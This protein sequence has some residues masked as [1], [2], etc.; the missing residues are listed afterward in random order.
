MHCEHSET[1]LTLLVTDELADGEEKQELLSHLEQCEA[2]RERLG[3]LRVTTRLL[4]EAAE[5]EPAP[6]LSAERRA[7]L[8]GAVGIAGHGVEQP[9][10]EETPG[11][12]D[13]PRRGPRFWRRL[14]PM[15][16]P[17]RSFV[18]TAAAAM[19]LVCL[20]GIITPTMYRDVD[21]LAGD[22]AL[23]ANTES[24]EDSPL[25]LKRIEKALEERL[26]STGE[27]VIHAP[28]LWLPERGEDVAFRDVPRTEAE[29]GIRRP[30]AGG[31]GDGDGDAGADGDGDGDGPGTGVDDGV[32]LAYFDA[33][34]EG[35]GNSVGSSES[36]K[37]EGRSDVQD[38]PKVIGHERM[39]S[40]PAAPEKEVTITADSGKGSLAPPDIST[41]NGQLSTPAR[42][43]W[44][45]S[46][47]RGRDEAEF[48]LELPDMNDVRTGGG[49]TIDGTG[50]DVVG[51]RSLNGNRAP[52]PGES[53]GN[54]RAREP[55]D[56]LVLGNDLNSISPK[57]S[58]VLGVTGS[59]D[60][61]GGIIQDGE[62]QT[63]TVTNGDSSTTLNSGSASRGRSS[64]GVVVDSG[65]TAKGAE[66]V[67]LTLGS[68]GSTQG[69]RV[70][71][72]EI[73]NG[74]IRANG[75]SPSEV[76]DG[77]EAND[78][79]E[80][81]GMDRITSTNSGD[82]LTAQ[83][84]Y[85]PKGDK[86]GEPNLTLITAGDV[87]LTNGAPR[88]QSGPAKGTSPDKWQHGQELLAKI[89][90]AES[91]KMQEKS[92]QV[93]ALADKAE[94]ELKLNQFDKALELIR[95]AEKWDKGDDRVQQLKV[96]WMI[97]TGNRPRTVSDIP[98]Y[99]E[100]QERVKV[101]M[102]VDEMEKL[103]RSANSFLDRRDYEEAI[104]R[105]EKA[106]AILGTLPD[107]EELKPYREESARKLA[108]ARQEKEENGRRAAHE[109]ERNARVILK[110]QREKVIALE[111]RKLE[112]ERLAATGRADLDLDGKKEVLVGVD[113]AM[114]PITTLY[115]YPENWQE[116]ISKRPADLAKERSEAQS[117][118][119][120]QMGKRISF[121]FV[122]TPLADVVAYLSKET[123][124]NIVLDP[125]AMQGD[126]VP[127]TLKATDMRADA[128]LAWVLRL[129]ALDSSTRDRAVFVSTKERI[130]QAPAVQVYEV[131]DLLAAI[132]D[133]SGTGLPGIGEGGGGGDSDLF[134]DAARKGEDFTGEDLVQFV[135]QT[136]DPANWDAEEADKSGGKDFAGK[137]DFR[138]G[139]LVVMQTG[140]AQAKIQK[141][142][143]DLR[144]SVKAKKDETERVEVKEEKPAEEPELPQ[145]VFKAVPVNPFV[146]TARDRFST[147]AI[148]VDTA[149]YAIARSY[150]RRGYLPPAASV[151][152]EEYINAF[153]YNYPSQNR[154]TFTTHVEAAP[155]PFGRDLT[156]VK[157]GI[158][159]KV[160]GRDGRK[161]AHLVFVVDT[162]GSMAKPDRMPLVQQ[163]LAFLLDSL[164]PTDRVSLVT[165]GTDARLILEAVPASEKKKI[166][167]AAKAVRCGGSTNLVKGVELGYAVA[168]RA[169]R[170]GHTNRVILC[171]DGV[172]NVGLTAAE[173]I[174]AKVRR[175]RE[176]GITF[177]SVG[178]GAGS[179]NDAL[180][181]RLAN[182]GDGTYMFVDS[183][184]QA[185]H[186]F[187]EQMAALQTIAKDV[188]IQ[189]EF[190]PRRVRRY[191]LIG[192]ENR[193]VADKDF[194]ND[195][196]DAGEVGSGQSATALYEV[197]LL[198]Q[199]GDE[200]VPADL[201]T[202]HL[203][204]RNVDTNEV[205]EVSYRLESSSVKKRTP[206]SD[207]RFFLAAAVAEFA[208]VLRQSEHASDGSLDNV[209]RVLERVAVELPLDQKVKE[210]L[211]LVRRAKGLPRAGK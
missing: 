23:T 117:K 183:R 209:E 118:L 133:Y 123:G 165:Y 200:A 177:T 201:G 129:T 112:K 106:R 136:I 139:K 128:A 143:D 39:V 7:A 149:S 142:L 162:S 146:M 119:A 19:L 72:P 164:D 3:D 51:G 30:G 97:L 158:R 84:Q 81:T 5:S 207:P 116:I 124:A 181:E 95:E 71:P 54:G 175:F 104:D 80:V 93:K 151:R 46:E 40:R 59:L 48:R 96:K 12:D 159:G 29:E 110:E 148:D 141:F 187:G 111:K 15:R 36:K 32:D 192:Y 189:V 184:E 60:M 1:L 161:P 100:Q 131:R 185:R 86:P 67:D 13:P 63:L 41:F 108:L 69:W 174:L 91:L 157:V 135:K 65:D 155:A 130:A 107:R 137:I 2:C 103:F 64:G 49:I 195:A 166:L 173:E 94:E 27:R 20:Y 199:P 147:F 24:A 10:T 4:R 121:D 66:D 114:V 197:E 79:I 145:A 206:K 33:H 68:L 178:F 61:G 170:A 168:G 194:R 75:D 109:G 14:S 18:A 38:T 138:Q 120:E 87:S 57:K 28:V 193:D 171:S 105:Y 134:G 172:A 204:Y 101:Q 43:G 208:E 153:D 31:D 47:I 70:R 144:K 22:I 42:R 140:E 98:G 125:A 210:L 150:I 154:N 179:Y 35:P 8:F 211:Q 196:V 77:R 11:P 113:E 126:D 90:T 152:M 92:F 21:E 188:K 25:D 45:V 202:V 198:E 44:E 78:L 99:K 58:D 88:P 186:V 26:R 89:A 122:D 53:V 132:P 85:R 50:G 34:V 205:E 167:D 82:T 102:N 156:L 62:G 6:K 76:D 180:L 169:F 74:G 190:D 83:V 191:R 182:Q 37:R 52:S 163:G 16:V 56:S 73:L 176:Q 17:A 127:V 203:R 115:E 9:V 160:I 55:D